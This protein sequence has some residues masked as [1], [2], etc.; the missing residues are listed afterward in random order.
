MLSLKKIPQSKKVGEIYIKA[1]KK[2]KETYL[3]GEEIYI[4]GNNLLIFKGN[5]FPPYETSKEIFDL[6]AQKGINEAKKIKGEFFV[7]FYNDT[8][9]KFYIAN[10]RL[11]RETLF[12]YH[13]KHDFILS[14][15]FWE[16]VNI[17]EPKETDIDVQSVKEFIIF[18]RPLFFKTIIRHLNFFP[19]ACIGKFSIKK[20]R[21]EL[22][23][24]W[25]FKY[26]PDETLELNE[27]VERLDKLLDGALKRIKEK[28]PKAIYGLGLS[29]G[30]DSRII[31]SYTLKHGM[32]LKSFIIGEK[33][34][35]KLLLSRS[36]LGARQIAKFYNLEH[37]EIEYDC[38]D[39]D[40]KS[41]H[42]LKYIPMVNAR[43]FHTV[44]EDKLPEFDILLTGMNGGEL[45]GANL[46]SN[47]QQLNEEELVDIIISNFSTAY[48]KS[49]STK[50]LKY[51]FNIGRKV[52]D[53]KR[54]NKLIKKEEFVKA[55]SKIREFVETELSKGK[56]NIDIFQK[57]LFFCLISNNKY[58]SFSMFWKKI[59]YSIFSDPYLF[60]EALKWK[61]DFLLNRRLQRHLYVKKFSRLAKIPAQDYRP[62]IFY[63]GK[64]SYLRKIFSL[65]DYFL[66]GKGLNYRKWEQEK[67]YLNFARRILSKENKLFEKAFNVKEILSSRSV[68][69]N[70]VK[71][72]QILDLIQSGEY[73]KFLDK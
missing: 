26:D 56:S 32:K 15:D 46:P 22:N 28:H 16:I 40:S 37:S 73:K 51:L 14:N 35:K 58:G 47:I 55:K 34:E 29:G 24:Y 18:N 70:L 25:D 60:E 63:R 44:D 5:T 57:Y 4:R 17:I 45:L 62:A 13:D 64:K 6:I 42:E 41:Y 12:Y 69:E 36:H 1:R 49:R 53:R 20:C 33:K 52:E 27:A 7:I 48:E 67:K 50:I 8:S 19:P 9:K 31:P 71:I 2:N 68:P 38:I 30:L 3:A 65:I 72:K 59:N 23:N 21:L 54:I 43:L 61:P 11:G 66:R 39:F 10:D